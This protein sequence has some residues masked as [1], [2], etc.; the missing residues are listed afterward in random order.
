VSTKTVFINRIGTTIGAEKMFFTN[1]VKRFLYIFANKI[2]AKMSD[3]VI[4]QCHYMA[5]D[6]LEQTKVTPKQYSVIYNPVKIDHIKNLAREENTEKYTFVAVG[7]LNPQKDYENLINACALL[8]NKTSDFSVAI[9]GQG[10]LFQKLEKLI[11]KLGLEKNVFLLGYKSN[12][13]SYINNSNYLVSSSLYEGFSNVIIESLC[14]GK[15]VIATDCPG[16]NAEVISNGANG[17]LCE[18]KN[19]EALANMMW[20]TLQHSV[21]LSRNEISKKSASLFSDDLI[22]DQYLKVIHN[23]YKYKNSLF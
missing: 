21:S 5:K 15:P 17:W 1:P 20:F 4:F 3:Y 2:I 14:L 18:Y 19:S 6:Y 12:P 8:K 13:Y 23:N 11:Q 9:L 16:G 10:N 7:R 22:F